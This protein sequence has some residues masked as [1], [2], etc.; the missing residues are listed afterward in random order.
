MSIC[1]VIAQDRLSFAFIKI[2]TT[3]IDEAYGTII[4]DVISADIHGEKT[5]RLMDKTQ[6]DRIAREEGIRDFDITDIKKIA[7][8]GKL[9]KVDKLIVGS[10][11]RQNGFRIDIRA[12]DSYG[13]STDLIYTDE[14][15]KEA[16]IIKSAKKAAEEI[17]RYYTGK[18][19][20]SEIM[21]IDINAVSQI[22]AGSYARF[23]YP[24]YGASL[25]V[26]KNNIFDERLGLFISG[27]INVFTPKTDRYKSFIQYSAAGG[28]NG[29]FRPFQTIIISPKVGAGPVWSRLN[30]DTDAINIP[31]FQ[32]E[33]RT[34]CN[35]FV[36]G[37]TELSLY[38]YDRWMLSVALGYANIIDSNNSGRLFTLG[39]G[40]KTLL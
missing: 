27:A 32:Y 20:V 19:H 30:Y 14:V 4:E 38:L 29:R 39:I 13:E 25:T 37:E 35:F 24:S 10:V 11:V 16:D 2:K 15:K 21:D 36:F 7:R 31:R 28:L 17:R 3:G 6:M 9:L 26:Y 1:P 33:K 40:I 23:L 8:S 22:P 12:I 18:G 34:F 5:F